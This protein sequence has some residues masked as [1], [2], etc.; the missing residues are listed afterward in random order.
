MDMACIKFADFDK[1]NPNYQFL[2][3]G[4]NDGNVKLLED[5]CKALISAPSL[6][7][8]FA[9]GVKAYLEMQGYEVTWPDSPK[10]LT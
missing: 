8:K 7:M 3:D 9:L 2:A 6:D 5:E 4:M 10:G 1:E